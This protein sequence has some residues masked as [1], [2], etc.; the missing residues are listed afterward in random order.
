MEKKSYTISNIM[1]IIGEFIVLYFSYV[2]C[3][4]WH[5]GMEITLFI[6]EY[7]IQDTYNYKSKHD[8]SEFFIYGFNREKGMFYGF[9][10][11]KQNEL[12]ICVKT[13]EIFLDNK[14]YNTIYLRQGIGDI[15][16]DNIIQNLFI[17]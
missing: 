12:D 4:V 14:Y 1:L 2:W 15:S 16:N 8:A 3:S 17:I 13:I 5:K 7:Y 10:Y 6:D 9:N 11:N